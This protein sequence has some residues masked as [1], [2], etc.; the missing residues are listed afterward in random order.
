MSTHSLDDFDTALW[1]LDEELQGRIDKPL[2][3]KAIGGYALLKHGIRDADTEFTADIDTV[4]DEFAPEVL[5]AIKRVGRKLDMDDDWLN[6][7]NVGDEGPEIVESLLQAE[8][9]DQDGDHANI[10]VAIAD[11]PTLTRAKIAAVDTIHINN[12]TKD[13]PDLIRLLD[14]QGI[15][16]LSEYRKLYPDD[17]EEHPT[18][19]EVISEHYGHKPS[20]KDPIV[21][22]DPDL[23]E[24]ADIDFE[25]VDLY[26]ADE[27]Y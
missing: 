15:S 6:T 9:E 12:R 3:I 17:R 10:K 21:S 8:W 14:A 25:N 20:K 27:Y 13:L 4:S 19:S 18:A 16:T 2:Q 11:L 5:A 26:S 1:H 7:D 22:R 24:F 23:L